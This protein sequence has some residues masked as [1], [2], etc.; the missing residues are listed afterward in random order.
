MADAPEPGTRRY[1]HRFVWG[2]PGDP[3]SA[4]PIDP[5]DLLEVEEWDGVQWLKRG[6]I[7]G[8]AFLAQHPR[9]AE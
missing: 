3:P 5:D 4:M 7:S 6:T 2:G 8:K 9:N 1:A